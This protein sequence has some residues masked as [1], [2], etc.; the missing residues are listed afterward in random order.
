MTGGSP[1]EEIVAAITCPTALHSKICELWEGD[2]RYAPLVEMLASEE[3]SFEQSARI[4]TDTVYRIMVLFGVPDKMRASPVGEAIDA[5]LQ[6]KEGSSM[7]AKD[8][9]RGSLE[10]GTIP[11][12]KRAR[13]L[14]AGE[15]FLLSL[16]CLGV[17]WRV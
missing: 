4:A 9:T 17:V 1:Y 15:C 16:A 7:F 12:L 5:Y 3:E 2:K 14:L 10:K 13:K 8:T 6:G 11:E